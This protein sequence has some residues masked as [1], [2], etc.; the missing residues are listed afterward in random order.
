MAMDARIRLCLA[1]SA[2]GDVAGCPPAFIDDWLRAA[3]GPAG[4]AWLVPDRQAQDAARLAVATD[5][6]TPVL[7][8]A[9]R[10]LRQAADAVVAFAAADRRVVAGPQVDELILEVLQEAA[11]ADRS[12]HFG[13]S[14]RHVATLRRAF[15]EL[16]S[17]SES[18]A[19]GQEGPVSREVRRLHQDYLRLLGRQRLLDDA[20]RLAKATEL[21]EGGDLGSLARVGF[22]LVS[23]FRRW[24]AG[25]QA[26]VVALSRVAAETVF[27]LPWRE[28]AALPNLGEAATGPPTP[29]TSVASTAGEV[30]SRFP[31]MPTELA[32][33]PPSDHDVIREWLFRDPRS[34]PKSHG[35]C[36]SRYRILAADSEQNELEVVAARVKALL[37]SGV[38]A[39]EILLASRSVDGIAERASHAF[40]DAGVPL[41]VDR[42]WRLRDASIYRTL[43]ALVR[44]AVEDWPRDGLLDLVTSPALSAFETPAHTARPTGFADARAASEWVLRELMLGGGEAKWIAQLEAYAGYDSR[45]GVAA[46]AAIPPIKRLQS[47]LASWRTAATP[48]AWF[49]RLRDTLAALGYRSGQGESAELDVAALDALEQTCASL[50]SLAAWR[51]QPA[52][53][54]GMVE[55]ADRL[56]SWSRS[57]TISLPS[58]LEGRVRLLSVESARLLRPRHLFVIGVSEQAFP[59]PVG[60]SLVDGLGRSADAHASDEM[61][62]FYELTQS[63]RETV[64]L[65]YPSL[66]AAGQPL[67]P[68]SFLAEVERLLPS[69][70]VSTAG[71][72]VAKNASSVSPQAV[73]RD[74]VRSLNEGDA[75]PLTTLLPRRGSPSPL[76]A[77][78]RVSLERATGDEFGFAEGVLIGDAARASLARRFSPEH[79][80]SPTQLETYAECPFKFYLR[81]VLGIEPPADYDLTIDYRRRGSLLHNAM[82]V[83]HQDLLGSEGRLEKLNSIGDGEFVQRFGAAVQHAKSASRGPSQEAGLIEIEAMQA[84]A[85]AGDYREQLEKYG[86][87]DESLGGAMR[88][89][90]FEVRFGPPRDPDEPMLPP[91][92]PDP[93]AI[94]LGDESLLI[95]GQVD[96]IDVGEI[97]GQRVFNVVDYKTARDVKARA[98]GLRDGRQLQ[99][100]LYAL[101]TERHLLAD[102]Q[103]QPWRL[104]YWALRDGGF[105]QPAENRKVLKAY[106]HAGGGVAP[107]QEWL[108]FGD[109]VRE[110]LAKIVDGVRRGEFPMHNADEHC[111]SRCEFRTT[112]RVGQ[113]R[114][115]E[116]TPPG[117]SNDD[118]GEKAASAE[119][120]T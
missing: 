95:T 34:A 37:L 33:A 31:G 5:R 27:V 83:L 114:S 51:S 66:D 93:F 40:A 102:D 104:G 10:T 117:E 44:L 92:R 38:D 14:G 49:D 47:Q 68:S 2:D 1:P 81:Q 120:T 32:N 57:V 61:L 11:S 103:A 75:S 106:D 100:Y 54:F 71:N 88:P 29:L 80:W 94:D 59:A 30:A 36:S 22:L 26:F 76:A 56:E 82:V 24:T 85:W 55:F 41:G 70:N 64:T 21:V 69:S 43:L 62:L 42:T 45:L 18:S 6:Q 17:A 15:A 116:K 77:S 90:Y 109:A 12:P 108:E 4:A 87:R 16:S 107:T 98:S 9:I 19:A 50:E 111:G 89:A 25:E 115:L 101:A 96:R 99:L 67:P 72:D 7:S 105:K 58:T 84:V 118:A 48:L 74:A 119:V 46:R 97:D 86:G 20:G 110:R 28:G 63:A 78:L 113:T 8:P 112:C 65:S 13:P 53:K 3:T 91:S 60:G 79:L 52:P 23:G 35:Q 39:G 73:A